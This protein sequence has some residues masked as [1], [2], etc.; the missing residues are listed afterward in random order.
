MT[1]SHVGPEKALTHS[2][3][4][5]YRNTVSVRYT[6]A[7]FAF[8]TKQQMDHITGAKVLPFF[9][10]MGHLLPSYDVVLGTLGVLNPAVLQCPAKIISWVIRAAAYVWKRAA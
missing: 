8:W 4:R 10:G 1:V 3:A 9:G 7:D 2:F 5:T 6:V